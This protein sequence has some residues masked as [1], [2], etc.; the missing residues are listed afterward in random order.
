MLLHHSRY[1]ARVDADGQLV[2]LEE[3]NRNLW[4]RDEIREGLKSLDVA[5]RAGAA[6]HH[7]H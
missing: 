7:T 4:N 2:L 5:L 6:V 1:L 3:Q